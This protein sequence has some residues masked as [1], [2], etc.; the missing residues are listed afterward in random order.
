MDRVSGRGRIRYYWDRRTWDSGKGSSS[1][2]VSQQTAGVVGTQPLCFSEVWIKKLVHRARLLE[3]TNPS[4][5]RDWALH[6]VT[7]CARISDLSDLNFNR[8]TGVFISMTTGEARVA[9]TH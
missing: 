7:I 1:L 3:G 2:E 8:L 6:S 9:R 4:Q 5:G